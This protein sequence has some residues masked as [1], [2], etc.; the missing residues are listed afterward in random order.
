MSGHS[1]L[2]ASTAVGS[3][4]LSQFVAPDRNCRLLLIPRAIYPYKAWGA[5]SSLDSWY[6]R[7]RD[8]N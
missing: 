1:V 5:G 8:L 2:I 7:A 4:T 3:G 6:A